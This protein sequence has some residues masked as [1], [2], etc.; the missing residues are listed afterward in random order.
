[1]HHNCN[2]TDQAISRKG[3]K[4]SM[5]VLAT[6]TRNKSQYNFDLIVCHATTHLRITLK[7]L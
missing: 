3:K 7:F 1:M 2:N 5:T 4:W 6:D